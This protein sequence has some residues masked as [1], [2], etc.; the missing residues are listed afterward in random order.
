MTHGSA[1]KPLGIAGVSRMM[2]AML[3][4]QVV[5]NSVVACVGP[6]GQTRLVFPLRRGLWRRSAHWPDRCRIHL[7]DGT[8]D[9]AIASIT[10]PTDLGDNLFDLWT[11]DGANYLDSGIDLAGG[12][13]F[14]FLT[15]GF[16]NGG[17]RQ[18]PYRRASS[19]RSM[20]DNR[21]LCDLGATTKEALVARR[22]TAG[23]SA[24]SVSWNASF[25]ASLRPWKPRCFATSTHGRRQDLTCSR[26][27]SALAQ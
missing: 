3:S 23:T 9:P 8:N 12:T 19:R 1:R 2:P 7:R 25:S 15:N 14:D 4:A 27:C 6:D 22:R 17:D 10:V 24:E 11:F 16:P 5:P 21:S 26:L 20:T 13:A 18:R